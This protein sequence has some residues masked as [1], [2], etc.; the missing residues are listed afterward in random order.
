MSSPAAFA[1]EL[2][3]GPELG[4]DGAGLSG[5]GKKRMRR[6]SAPRLPYVE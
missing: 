3:A 2:D 4:G 6:A 5:I 1:G